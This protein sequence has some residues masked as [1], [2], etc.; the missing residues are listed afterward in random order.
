MTQEEQSKEQEEDK[1]LHLDI[2]NIE[3]LLQ[4]I[5][6]IDHQAKVALLQAIQETDH[7]AKVDHLKAT[8]MLHRDRDQHK[9]DSKLAICSVTLILLVE[10]VEIFNGSNK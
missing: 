5:Q 7:Q 9:E 6:E 2:H 8:R 1:D 3:A 4:A 10:T